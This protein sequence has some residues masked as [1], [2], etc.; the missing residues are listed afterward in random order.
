MAGLSLL[1]LWLHSR[2]LDWARMAVHQMHRMKSNDKNNDV[3]GQKGWL[4]LRISQ[5]VQAGYSNGASD[6]KRATFLAAHQDINLQL[7]T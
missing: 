2:F 5:H 1:A 4:H 6:H 3:V 7:P